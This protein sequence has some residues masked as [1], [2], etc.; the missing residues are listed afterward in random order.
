MR[1]RI[2]H[3]IRFMVGLLWAG[4]FLTVPQVWTAEE[5]PTVTPA[6]LY[7]LLQ[8]KSAQIF[9][10]DVRT[11]EEYRDAHIPGT[12]A[13]IDYRE[14]ERM[15]KRLPGDPDTP[16]IVYCRSG[17]RSAVALKTLRKLGY[18]HVRHLEGGI[19]KWMAQ[20]YPV[21]SDTP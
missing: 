2:T 4:L 13:R 16:I 3:R 19:R 7:A 11:P 15:R 6:E 12:D 21:E 1:S 17:R 5:V 18:T 9:L 20:G 10:L 14:L 8:Q